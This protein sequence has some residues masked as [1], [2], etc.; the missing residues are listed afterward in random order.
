M[1]YLLVWASVWSLVLTDALHSPPTAVHRVPVLAK[2]DKFRQ[3]A[4]RHIASVLAAPCV[5]RLSSRAEGCGCVLY[6]ARQMQ[7]EQRES[8]LPS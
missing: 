3:R 2:A 4:R 5:P 6:A 8:L 7:G 1:S